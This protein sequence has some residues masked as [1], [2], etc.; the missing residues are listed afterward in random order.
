VDIAWQI[1][2]NTIN[3]VS[4]RWRQNYIRRADS[5][6]T[7]RSTHAMLWLASRRKQVTCGDQP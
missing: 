2:S 4:P 1:A 3:Q 7:V 5:S 6:S